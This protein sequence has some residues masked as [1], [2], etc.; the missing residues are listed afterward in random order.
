[1]EALIGTIIG[2][3]IALIGTWISTKRSTQAQMNA[4]VLSTI[5]PARL[6]AYRRLH[7][8]LSEWSN[9]VSADSYAVLYQECD[10]VLLVASKETAICLKKVVNAIKDFELMGFESVDL[11]QFR[12]LYN[13][14]V[15]QMNHD[16]MHIQAPKI[17]E[18]K[19]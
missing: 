12:D 6:D 13:D 18:N 3:L 8:A 5:L 15:K 17:E 19:G 16:L 9:S 10:A 14:L 1:M 4:A 2:A 7:S 11:I